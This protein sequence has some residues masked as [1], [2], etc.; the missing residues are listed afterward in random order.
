MVY[1]IWLDLLINGLERTI[2]GEKNLKKKTYGWIP[3]SDMYC[4]DFGISHNCQPEKMY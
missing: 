1:G 4:A 2:L 3:G